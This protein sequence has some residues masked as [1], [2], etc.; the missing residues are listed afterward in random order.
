MTATP[1]IRVIHL[2]N[3]LEIGGAELLLLETLRRFDPVRFHCRVATLLG[4]GRLGARFREAGIEVVDLSKDGRFTWGASR[5]LRHLMRRERCDILHGHLVH[6]TVMGRWLRRTRGARRFVSTQHFPPSDRARE[7]SRR[8]HRWTAKW[9]D[10]TVAVS[11]SIADDLMREVGVPKDQVCVIENGVDLARFHPGIDPLPRAQFGL[12]ATHR[13]IGTT[14][15]LSPVKGLDVLI[16]AAALVVRDVPEA[17]FVIAGE[18][19][20]RAALE[21][22]IATAQ[23]G[24]S[25]RLVGAIEDVP[26]FLAMLDLFCLP[27]RRETFGLSAAEAMA[28]GCAVVHSRVPGLDSLSTSGLTAIQVDRHEDPEAWAREIVSLLQTPEK[29][30]ALGERAA[31][32]AAE[33]FGIER[34]VN[35]LAALYER[36]VE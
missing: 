36:T 29:A 28:C 25:I 1:A 15:R 16:R 21:R 5:R 17:R 11:Q 32:H 10:A 31:A 30:T 24:D 2:I 14:A 7:F 3:D 27:S 33:R 8:L 6:A 19:P 12:A 4:P 18:G 22:A 26:R 20:E 35:Q 13:V 34:T 9:D 23:L